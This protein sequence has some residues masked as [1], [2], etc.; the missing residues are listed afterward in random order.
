MDWLKGNWLKALLLIFAIAGWVAHQEI[1]T[2]E[3]KGHRQAV[4]YEQCVKHC[5]AWCMYHG[6]LTEMVKL[7]ESMPRSVLYAR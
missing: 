6:P 4:C 3:G 7:M 2:L 5:Q 1:D